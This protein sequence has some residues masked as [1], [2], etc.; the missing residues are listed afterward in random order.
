[1]KRR[2]GNLRLYVVGAAFVVSIGVLW[3]RLI[4]VQY[5]RHDY[6]A[7]VADRQ[8]IR[9][10]DIPAAR[11]GIFD[12]NGRPLALNASLCSIAVSPDRVKSSYRTAVSVARV[13]GVSRDRV[14]A[15]IRSSKNFVYV[16]RQVELDDHQRAKLRAIDGVTVETEPGRL[17]P[18]GG[19][20]A[21]IVGFV[22]YDNDGRAGVEVACDG[23]LRGIPGRERII[24]N[25]RYKSDRYHRIVERQPENGKQVYLTIDTRLQEIAEN[26]VSRAVSEH[27]ARSGAI[28][29]MQVAT[30]EILAL[31]EYPSPSTRRPGSRVDSLWTVRCLSHVYEPGSTFKVVTAAALLEAG[32]VDPSDRF[33]A[34][35][36]RANLGFAVI[37]DPHPHDVLTFEEAFAYSSNIIMAKASRLISAEEFYKYARLFGFG[38]KTGVRLKGESAGSVKDVSSW[39]LRTQSTMAFGQEVAV[40]PLQMLSAYAAIA[41]DGVMMLPRFIRGFADVENESVTRFGPVRVRR[42]VSP[43]TARTLRSFCRDVVEYGTG[44]AAAVDFIDV[45]GKTGTGQKASGGGYQDGKYVSSFVGFAPNESPRIACLV[46]LDEPKWSSRYGGDSAAPVFARVCHEIANTTDIFDGAL[47]T[48]TVSVPRATDQRFVAPNFIRME[49]AAALE[50]ARSVGTNV[51]CQG[52]GGRV[53]AQHPAPNTPM[54]RDGVI[55]L[56]VSEG[57][58]PGHRGK[59]TPD[60]R[61]LTMRAA[62]RRAAAQGFE[63]RFVGSGVVNRQSPAPGRK[64][65]IDAVRLY[66]DAGGRRGVG[67]RGG[68]AR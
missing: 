61:G 2:R 60:L 31:A 5:F 26:E 19:V 10:R 30:G 57:G 7:G 22:G 25:G 59:R 27:G 24:Q 15:K 52:E 51:L 62:K 3:A 29:V 12:R 34:E 17:Y 41:N 38:S 39:S 63:A 68:G 44:V 4:Q 32:H 58:A 53:I 13:L 37:N 54:D 21:K 11:G 20:A 6:Y 66:C 23:E 64:T 36:G 18:Y 8:R 46:L 45:S 40:T 43:E 14:L 35:H 65:N 28:I 1:M 48:R 47:I 16:A 49:R 55:H 9:P 50:R 56:V 42:V 33:D 67:A